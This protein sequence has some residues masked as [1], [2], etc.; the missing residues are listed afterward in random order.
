[1]REKGMNRD[2]IKYIAMFTMLLN[3][4]AAVFMEPGAWLTELFLN[5]GYFTAP[6]MCYFLVEGYAYTRSK[7]K[8]G[9]RLLIFGIISELPFCLAFSE[10]ETLSFTSM[11]MIVTLFLCFLLICVRKEVMN[12]FLRDFFTALLIFASLFSDWGI[13][14]PVF[15]L[16]FL[17]AGNSEQKKKNAF[18]LGTLLFGLSHLLEETGQLPLLVNVTGMLESMLGPGL[19]GI[20]ILF[21]Y[22]G[23]RARKYR[24]FSKWFFYWFYSVHLTVLGILRIYLK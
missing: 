11:N 12:P 20:C 18:L 5:L 22:N 14:A 21:F 1:M 3:H 10:G 17:N 16:L 24:K 7:R 4:I 2:T 9:E 19:A 13:L 8:Y 15:T 6:V 23:K